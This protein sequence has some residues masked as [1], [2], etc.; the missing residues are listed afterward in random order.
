M[1]YYDEVNKIIPCFALVILLECCISLFSLLLSSSLLVP[2]EPLQ[3]R[4]C[5]WLE[6]NP[7]RQLQRRLVDRASPGPRGG[8]VG[9][10]DTADLVVYPRAQ[11]AC[12]FR[13]VYRIAFLC[14]IMY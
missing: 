2:R 8:G 11:G 13:Q 9:S 3:R 1:C 10:E 7:P 6:W 5:L 14:I 12:V 4:E